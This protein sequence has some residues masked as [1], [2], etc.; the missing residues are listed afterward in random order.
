MDFKTYIT[1]VEKQLKQ[2]TEA[3]KTDWIY[4]QAR[5][6]DEKDRQGLL[7]SLYGKKEIHMKLTK[8]EI[9]D[10]CQKV[11]EGEIYLEAELS[12][13]YEER[14][15][16]S[17]WIVE[18]HDTFG[19]MPY[20]TKAIDTCNQ[21]VEKK[22]YA[23]A[24]E[25]LDRICC[26]EFHAEYNEDYGYEDYDEDG[27]TLEDLVKKE[28]LLLDFRK[29]SLNLLYTCYQTNTGQDRLELLYEYLTWRMTD[30]ILITDIFAFG[31]EEIKDA[32]MFMQEWCA[33][34][35]QISEDRAAELLVDAC[36]YL[37][38]DEYLLKTAGEYAELHPFLYQAYCEKKYQLADYQACIQ[39]AKEALDRID[40]NKVIRSDISDIAVMAA[41]KANMDSELNRFY[42]AAFYSN[43]NSW[44]LLRLYKLK[45]PTV[46]K[47]ALERIERLPVGSQMGTENPREQRE[48]L[49][50][51][52]R[53]TICQFLLGD[54]DNVLR[55]CKQDNEYLGWSY[56]KKSMI[57][58]LLL[59]YLK[60][61]EKQKTVA[62]RNLLDELDERLNFD[63]K[64]DES[65]SEYISIWR[66]SYVMPKEQEEACIKWLLEEVDKRTAEIVGGGHR[67]SY[68]KAAELIV[69][70]GEIQEERGEAGG[71]RRL[72]DHYKSMHS[73][74][75]AFKSEIEGLA[76]RN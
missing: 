51:D 3:E 53:R 52:D 48:V 35:I 37:G 16:D 21:L 20:L 10:W 31:P 60:K 72:I 50:Y 7:N 54:Y 39:A 23:N 66:Q 33:Y 63:S 76:K 27:L 65:F 44:H 11:E 46:L 69:V 8:E 6:V 30:K 1:K 45:D 56:G 58:L 34:L 64:E 43:P 18:Y 25:L 22:E 29:L 70:M 61:D 38:S 42:F 55:Q 67:K 40:G 17:D 13:Y 59:I 32:N 36:I 68:Y 47:E 2:M 49:I 5:K 74:K 24:Y 75:T 28:L 41:K 12:E 71:M 57:I 73:R 19:A 4:A 9:L 62:E 14:G 26:L 15:W